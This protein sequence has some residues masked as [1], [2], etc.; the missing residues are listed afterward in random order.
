MATGI[1][2]HHQL[3][4]PWNCLHMPR[5]VL[6]AAATQRQHCSTPVK[7]PTNQ[8]T[9]VHLHQL[10]Q[11]AYMG[12][13]GTTTT[14]TPDRDALCLPETTGPPR[15]H[16]AP[17]LTTDQL[18]DHPCKHTHA[19]ARVSLSPCHHTFR[20]CGAEKPL[21]DAGHRQCCQHG[22]PH[23]MLHSTIIPTPSCARGQHIAA[24][25]PHVATKT[26][27]NSPRP[28][29]VATSS[30]SAS[31]LRFSRASRVLKLE[32]LPNQAHPLCYAHP[33]A[34]MPACHTH[35]CAPMRS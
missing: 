35:P 2:K 27:I 5:C 20:V 14:P 16:A 23:R 24:T 6:C 15:H 31:L 1:I 29:A 10:A 8:T 33:C 25:Q 17:A 3:R 34:P 7:R 4:R 9:H 19:S 12:A 26:V 13:G 30:H 32:W 28:L 21:R 22:R 11:A 18:T